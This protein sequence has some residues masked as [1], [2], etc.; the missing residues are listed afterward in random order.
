MVLNKQQ[1]KTLLKDTTQ[2]LRWRWDSNQQPFDPQSNT[3][4]TEPLGSALFWLRNF[5]I[6]NLVA[7]KMISY[8]QA[9]PLILHKRI[10]IPRLNHQAIYIGLY[11][12]CWKNKELTTASTCMEQI[13]KNF[14]QYPVTWQKAQYKQCRPRSV[15]SGSPLFAILRS[16]WWFNDLKIKILTIL[17]EIS[18]KSVWNFWMFN[19]LTIHRHKIFQNRS[20]EGREV[21]QLNMKEKHTKN[22]YSSTKGVKTIC[23]Y[24]SKME[25]Y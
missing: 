8:C 9:H 3:L 6:G 24:S 19:S 2:W 4:P 14:K 21:K 22:N 13:F 23:L 17:R 11:M 7:M 12:R 20:E 1:I 18:E 15:W 16:I 5:I 25:G 10:L